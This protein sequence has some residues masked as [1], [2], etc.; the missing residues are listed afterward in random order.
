MS[1]VKPRLEP[2]GQYRDLTVPH[3]QNETDTET[4]EAGLGNQS[5]SFYCTVCPV[6]TNQKT[7]TLT[8]DWPV[9]DKRNAN[10]KVTSS[11]QMVKLKT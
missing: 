10:G 9:T 5:G 7:N 8:N 3:I 6:E 2:E 11:G 4:S 1:S